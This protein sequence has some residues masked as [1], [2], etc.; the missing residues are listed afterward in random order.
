MFVELQPPPRFP[1][2]W[3]DLALMTPTPQARPTRNRLDLLHVSVT[4][5]RMGWEIT[6]S[7]PCG[8]V[9]LPVGAATGAWRTCL[10]RVFEPHLGPARARTQVIMYPFI[11]IAVIVALGRKRFLRP[12]TMDYERSD[13]TLRTVHRASQGLSWRHAESADSESESGPTTGRRDGWFGEAPAFGTILW[14]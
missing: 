2:V 6:H 1:S 3:L 5:H 4:S 11:G 12:R 14:Y 9:G 8:R 13:R 7:S 10:Y